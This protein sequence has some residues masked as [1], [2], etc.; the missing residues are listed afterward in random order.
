MNKYASF[1]VAA[2]ILLTACEDENDS[3]GVGILEGY[4]IFAEMADIL[5]LEDVVIRSVSLAFPTDDPYEFVQIIHFGPKKLNDCRNELFSSVYHC[6]P[7]VT[8]A[9]E[10]STLI[11]FD[12]G[13]ADTAQFTL[14][15]DRLTVFSEEMVTINDT[16]FTLREQGILVRYTGDFPPQEWL[17]PLSNDDYEPDADPGSATSIAVGATAQRH[18]LVP[19]DVDWFSFAAPA[20][21]T[22]VIETTGLVDTYLYL[23]ESDGSTLL[24][25][26]DDGGS[27][28]NARIDWAFSTSGTYYFKVSGDGA[29]NAGI[30]RVL[31]VT[32]SGVQAREVI[33]TERA[34][35]RRSFLFRLIRITAA[36]GR[37]RH[38]LGNI[39]GMSS[40]PPGW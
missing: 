24:E 23:Y 6:Y 29:E 17:T 33:P 10:D 21:T 3:D 35:E 13:G 39:Y 38:R 4:W 22:Y 36:A 37:T 18:V 19:G 27:Y 20:G 15:E 7:E 25:S 30:Y 40:V 12:E 11:T 8:Y 2:A 32:G 34:K 28:L 1:L 5:L 31:V 26:D 14:S 9:V 16:T